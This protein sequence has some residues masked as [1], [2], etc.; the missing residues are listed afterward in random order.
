MI[1]RKKLRSLILRLLV[2]TAAGFALPCSWV[3]LTAQSADVPTAR[4]TAL[5][6]TVRPAGA[7]AVQGAGV[8][9]TGQLTPIAAVASKNF[10]F[11]KWEGA[12]VLN[13]YQALTEVFLNSASQ[14][15]VAVFAPV[16][17]SVTVTVVPAESATVLGTGS[18]PP[19]AQP[20]L[21]LTPA[22]GCAF[23]G[24][25]GP[26]AQKG[27]LETKLAKPLTESVQLTARFNVAGEQNPL[28]VAVSPADA[29]KVS[30]AGIYR[31]GELV[32][33]SV[34]PNPNYVFN[35]WKGPVVDPSKKKTS[36][37]VTKETAVQAML[38][39]QR[40]FARAFVQ[41]AHGG[42]VHGELG[43]RPCGV[44]SRLSAEPAPGYVFER[45]IGPVANATSSETIFTPVP[46][47]S[48]VITAI[49]K[50][51]YQ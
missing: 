9:P 20:T 48:I 38:V 10:Y 28:T 6:I 25:E 29:G 15:L 7:G 37:F 32:E 31:R 34:E 45:W 51:K 47:K 42:K 43:V 30:G 50:P 14:T 22:P 2:V 18:F 40:V 24:W 16:K 19:G 26:V 3:Q 1:M 11:Q 35:G 44:A 39:P 5:V 21:K 12:Q 41:P 17:H 36:V 46:G 13:P 23:I 49:F 8:L 27:A 4:T 33:I